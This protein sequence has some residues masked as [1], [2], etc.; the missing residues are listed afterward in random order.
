[1]FTSTAVASEESTSVNQE[2]TQLIKRDY[3]GQV[4][5][6]IQE[7]RKIIDALQTRVTFL[8]KINYDKFGRTDYASAELGG[9][10]ISVL[11]SK[12]F[13]HI[14]TFIERGLGIGRFKATN[15][16]CCIIQVISN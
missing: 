8:E 6:E 16:H 1:M 9:R 11:P 7:A 15:K 4:I 10:V 2:G 14:W 5:H 13:S 12:R 3:Q